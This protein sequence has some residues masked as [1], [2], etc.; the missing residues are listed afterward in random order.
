MGRRLVYLDSSAIIR[1]VE[2]EL[3][4]AEHVLG[5]V[6]TRR[7]IT[8]AISLTECFVKPL[9]QAR[10]AL[11]PK[12]QA[13]FRSTDLDVHAIGIQTALLAADLRVA[14]KLKTPD[15][16]HLAV[17]K[18]QE[19]DAFVTADRGFDRCRSVGPE[20]IIVPAV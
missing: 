20:I 11:L 4:L 18:L 16:L 12:Y 15:A 2:T 7:Q 6:G 10:L 19:C 9:Q 14:F 8:C 5:A 17:A 3:R 13:F 1:L